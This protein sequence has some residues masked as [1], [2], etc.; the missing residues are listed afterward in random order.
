MRKKVELEK[1]DWKLLSGTGMRDYLLKVESYHTY[2]ST[3]GELMNLRTFCLSSALKIFSSYF[4]FFSVI[5]LSV[6]AD[7]WIL[8]I[9]ALSFVF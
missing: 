5:I 7:R 6:S 9:L 3:F 1:L 2:A 8:E 4:F